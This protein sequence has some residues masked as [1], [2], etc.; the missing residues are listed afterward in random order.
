MEVNSVDIYDYIQKV[1]LESCYNGHFDKIKFIYKLCIENNI[2]I[3]IMDDAF[4]ACRENN[5]IDIC[6]WFVSRNNHSLYS[7][8]KP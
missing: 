3:A 8:L 6:E 5:Y 7:I 2:H 4:V 1:F